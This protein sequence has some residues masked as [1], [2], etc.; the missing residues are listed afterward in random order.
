[1]PCHCLLLSLP[2]SLL[3]Q[4]GQFNYLARRSLQTRSFVAE[5]QA[6]KQDF[7]AGMCPL[8]PN[9]RRHEQFVEAVLF[10]RI[11]PE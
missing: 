1:M 7:L 4:H 11:A 8:L 2:R 6:P 10:Q 9:F 5:S 3:S